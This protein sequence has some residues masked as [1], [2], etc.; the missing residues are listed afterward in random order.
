MSIVV[1]SLKLTCL[2]VLFLIA[3][4]YYLEGQ[5]A[6]WTISNRV[7]QMSDD[8]AMANECGTGVGVPDTVP[9]LRGSVSEPNPVTPPSH[10][11]ESGRMT[12]G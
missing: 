6:E 2:V 4:A 11:R 5:E 3:P 12:V 8:A 9:L 7:D 1:R 10:S